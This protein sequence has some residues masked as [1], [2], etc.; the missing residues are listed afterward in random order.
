[1]NGAKVLRWRQHF[2]NFERSFQQLTAA[3]V[4]LDELSDLEKDGLFQR[5]EYPFELAWK[6]LKDNLE[7]QVLSSNSLATWYAENFTTS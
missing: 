6:T 1:M 5:F 2:Q 7:S 4:R 3:V